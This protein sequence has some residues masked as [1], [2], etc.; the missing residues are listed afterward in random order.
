MSETLKAYTVVGLMP[1]GQRIAAWVH[2]RN[3]EDA[4]VVVRLPGFPQNT[5]DNAYGEELQIAG[6]FNG[7]LIAV[8]EQ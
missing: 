3:P 2:A 7:H 6:V 1:D 4:E 8:D 5:D